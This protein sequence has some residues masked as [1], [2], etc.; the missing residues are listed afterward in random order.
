MQAS[1]SRYSS[2]SKVISASRYSSSSRASYSSSSSSLAHCYATSA[3][4]ASAYSATATPT[5]CAPKYTAGATTISGTGT[6]PKPT[7]FVKRSG[8]ALTLDGT[9]FRIV[10][11][12]IYWLCSDENIAGVAKGTP[13]DKGRIREALA[14]AVAMGA[15]TVR[16]M[17]CGVSVGSSNSLEPTLNKFA[18]DDSDVWDTHDYV[19]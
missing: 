18:D 11:P 15:N 10:G 9:N 16:L 7:S 6:L 3:S 4:L 19:L 17:S 14:I 2:S 1:A 13:T 12:N 5:T 8:E